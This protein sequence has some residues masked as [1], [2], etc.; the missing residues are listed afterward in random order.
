MPMGAAVIRV[1]LC[2]GCL[3]DGRAHWADLRLRREYWRT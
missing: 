2:M 3:H 1:G